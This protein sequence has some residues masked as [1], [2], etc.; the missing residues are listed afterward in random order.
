MPPAGPGASGVVTHPA[1]FVR[2]SHDDP[3]FDT[4]PAGRAP[5]VLN[6]LSGE[7]G[8]VTSAHRNG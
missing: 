8:I 3:A 5:I 4:A 2:P 1:T 7:I 6:P